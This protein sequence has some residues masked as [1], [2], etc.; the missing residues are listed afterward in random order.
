[1]IFTLH[2]DPQL[3]NESAKGSDLRRCRECVY[4]SLSDLGESDFEQRGP[5]LKAIWKLQLQ[6]RDNDTTGEY[7]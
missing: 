5:L 4:F 2:T 6:V 1:M 7:R 3:E